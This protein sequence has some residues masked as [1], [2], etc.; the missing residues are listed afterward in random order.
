MA[1]ALA[2]EARRDAVGKGLDKPRET[3]FVPY[4]I[5]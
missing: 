4:R 5:R 1:A 2:Y 3:M